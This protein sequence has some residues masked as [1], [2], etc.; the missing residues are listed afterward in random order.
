M[1]PNNPCIS[2]VV[3][4]A[5]LVQKPQWKKGVRLTP[6]DTRVQLPHP[7]ILQARLRIGI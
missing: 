6:K 4:R 1:L 7:E 5:S 2:G 3:D